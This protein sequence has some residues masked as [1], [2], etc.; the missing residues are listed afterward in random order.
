MDRLLSLLTPFWG[1]HPRKSVKKYNNNAIRRATTNIY[2]HQRDKTAYRTSV[3]NEQV[4]AQLSKPSFEDI[5]Q[6]MLR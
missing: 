2:A 1:T 6:P 3:T 5:S 4:S